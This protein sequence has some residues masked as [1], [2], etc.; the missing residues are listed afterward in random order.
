MI[1]CRKLVRCCLSSSIGSR[2]VLRS[3]MNSK[4]LNIVE[5]S[6]AFDEA[7]GNFVGDFQ[8]EADR[9]TEMFIKQHILSSFPN[10]RIIGEESVEGHLPNEEVEGDLPSISDFIIDQ[11]IPI[12]L[13]SLLE[14]DL[15]IY[16]DPL[17]GTNGFTKGKFHDVTTLVGISYKSYPLIG[18]V[19]EPFSTTNRLGYAAV[20]GGPVMEL[21]SNEPSIH[22]EACNVVG[23][24]L[25][26]QAPISELSGGPASV[27]FTDTRL[28]PFMS[29]VMNR[30]DTMN[31]TV[32]R[33]PLERHPTGGAGRK[34]MDV[35]LGRADMF[36]NPRPGTKRWDSCAPEAIL[37]AAGYSVSDSLGNQIVY[38]GEDGNESSPHVL[39][40]FGV[41]AS[42][43]NAEWHKKW[44]LEPQWLEA[45]Y[46]ISNMTEEAKW[47]V[48]WENTLMNLPNK[49]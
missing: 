31:Q 36:F 15:C 26:I 23:S 37:I 27:V 2:N 17:D 3:F 10:I 47:F 18:I 22:D 32:N 30:V 39:N 21:Q 44:V 41:T 28:T 49:L 46:T 38:G 45:K 35:L 24:K 11:M 43:G 29:R 12:N 16:I 48:G 8:T 9:R 33:S 40:T 4:N 20:V 34:Y 14:E 5:K 1:D 6:D 13:D 7:S 42:R 25:S 19:L